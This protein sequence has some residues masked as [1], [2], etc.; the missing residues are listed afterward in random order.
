MLAKGFVECEPGHQGAQAYQLMFLVNDRIK[1]FAKEVG[2]C[3]C[4]GVMK[5]YQKTGG[6]SGL[7][8]ILQYLIPSGNPYYLRTSEFFSAN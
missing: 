4:L 3:G 1:A 6:E 5:I 7:A 8:G 2:G